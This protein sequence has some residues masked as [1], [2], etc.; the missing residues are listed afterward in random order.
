MVQDVNELIINY[1][2]LIF[3]K[4]IRIL[5]AKKMCFLCLT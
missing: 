1:L 5:L 4:K 3:C 2:I